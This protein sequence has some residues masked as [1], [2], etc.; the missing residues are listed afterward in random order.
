MDPACKAL[1]WH[2]TVVCI[3]S[4]TPLIAMLALQVWHWELAVLWAIALLMLFLEAATLSLHRH[5]RVLITS[6]ALSISRSAVPF[7]LCQCWSQAQIYRS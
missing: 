1:V 7:M 2:G 5:R 3:Y 4:F 6:A